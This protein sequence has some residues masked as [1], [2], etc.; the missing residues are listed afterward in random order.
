L[1]A[2]EEAYGGP[3]ALKK[4]INCAHQN[5]IAVI[6]DVVYNHLGIEDNLLWRY[7]GSGEA[8]G[9]YFYND[10][11][12]QTPWGERPNYSAPRVRNYIRDNAMNW[13]DET[14]WTACAGMPACT[15][16]LA[17]VEFVQRG[18]FCPWLA[19]DAVHQ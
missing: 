14:A 8:G 11:R 4:M 17:R 3:Q 13:L 7:D 19:V 9:I 5:G 15:F 2:V 6:M 16:A 1:F 10:H 18:V 12:R